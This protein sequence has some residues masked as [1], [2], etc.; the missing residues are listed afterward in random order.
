VTVPASAS[1]RIELRIAL[2]PVQIELPEHA[3]H[4]QGFTGRGACY[5]R[6]NEDNRSSFRNRDNGLFAG[7][8]AFVYEGCHV[9]E[10]QLKAEPE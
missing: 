9:L 1:A 2:S 5:M 10:L 8:C 4:G 3:S 7:A 6:R